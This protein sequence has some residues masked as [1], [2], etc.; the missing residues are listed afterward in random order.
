MGVRGVKPKPVCTAGK[1]SGHGDGQEEAGDGS[2][3]VDDVEVKGDVIEIAE[4]AMI[5][6]MKSPGCPTKEEVER[7]YTTH[8]PYRSWCPVCVQGKGKEAP[9][10]SKT[11]KRVGE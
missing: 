9:H 11:E 4:E 7:H 6:V 3:D 5:K 8:L 10:A 1:D 2:V